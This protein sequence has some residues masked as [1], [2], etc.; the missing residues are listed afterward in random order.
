MPDAVKTIQLLIAPVVMISACGLLCLAL[1]NRL[2][3]IVSR[4]RAFHKERFDIEMKLAAPDPPAGM[5]GEHLRR[6]FDSLA[7]QAD[8]VLARARKVRSALLAF[9]GVILCM[10]ASSLAL[11]LSLA[12]PG[13]G[14]LALALFLAGVCLGCAGTLLAMLELTRALDPITME[15]TAFEDPIP[16]A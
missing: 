11:G 7:E 1:Y 2:A 8:G 10:L 4:A 15:Y 16:H 3:A 13:F 6:R 12:R 14:G 9:L 5:I